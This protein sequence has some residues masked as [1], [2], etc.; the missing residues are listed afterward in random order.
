MPQNRAE[1]TRWAAG[2][3]RS[4]R[5]ATLAAVIHAA[6]ASPVVVAIQS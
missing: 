5:G 1:T 4:A 2:K 6:N 3:D